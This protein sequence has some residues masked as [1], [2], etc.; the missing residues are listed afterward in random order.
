MWSKEGSRRKPR[1]PPNPT[2]RQAGR[3]ALPPA[4]KASLSTKRKTLGLLSQHAYAPSHMQAVKYESKHCLGFLAAIT[5]LTRFLL[6]CRAVVLS[7]KLLKVHYASYTKFQEYI[8]VYETWAGLTKPSTCGSVQSGQHNQPSR[9][10]PFASAPRAP[11]L[12]RRSHPCVCAS[13]WTP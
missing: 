11:E 1:R 9:L 5:V 7:S 13:W 12:P 8:S 10:R 3:A 6:R 4:R 2:T